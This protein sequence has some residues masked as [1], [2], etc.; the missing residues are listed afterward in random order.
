MFGDEVAPDDVS[1]AVGPSTE[2]TGTSNSGGALAHKT[3]ER[4]GGDD[5]VA[6]TAGLDP[7][8]IQAMRAG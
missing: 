6:M 5:L 8:W 3:R 4:A 1:S 2:G 7:D